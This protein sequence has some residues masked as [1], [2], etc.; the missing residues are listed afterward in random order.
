MKNIIERVHT[1]LKNGSEIKTDSRK[2]ERGDIFLALKGENFD[3]NDFAEEALERGAVLVV[4]DNEKKYRLL[5]ESFSERVFRVEDSMTF[6]WKLAK[7]HRKELKIPFLA[8]TGSNGKTTTKELISAVLS[9]KYRVAAT[10]GNFN[11]HLGVP[12]TILAIG[13]KDDFAVIEMGANHSGEIKKLSELVEPDYG[14]IT[15]VSSA[16][17]GEFGSFENIKRSK[18]ELYDAVLKKGG[19]IFLDPKDHH[20]MEMAADFLPE[21][22]IYY[23]VGRILESNPFL[24]MEIAGQKIQSRIIGRY[25]LLN[26]RAAFTAGDYFAV[27][28]PAIVEALE[29]YEPVNNRSQFVEKTIRGNDLILDCYN[30][31]PESMSLAIDSFL[32]M[33]AKKEKVFVLG[34]MAE[35]G[36]YSEKEHLKIL[37]KI[38]KEKGQKFLIG[39]EFYRL[40][41]KFPA[42]KY[43]I[44][45]DAF[46]DHLKSNPLENKF[47]FLKGSNSVNLIRLYQ[48]GAV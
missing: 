25:N 43:F 8:I 30:A 21:D 5:E 24:L 37:N 16:H 44:S 14:L 4:M 45:V 1:H 3:G 20:L 34:Q 6:L 13:E 29:S 23:R 11:N 27:D 9:K 22:K 12:L 42:F 10:T 47:I 19:K 31:N 41:K 48:E 17:L 7:K 35:L 33:D 32:E 36:E 38:K 26:Y 40:R 2:V 28:R 18:K 46:L 39:E 15:N